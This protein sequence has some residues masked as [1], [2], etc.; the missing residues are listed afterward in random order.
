M[1]HSQDLNLDISLGGIYLGTTRSSGCSSPEHETKNL[2]FENWL[3]GLII[4]FLISDRK[5]A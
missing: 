5:K 2:S 3:A 1:R 4:I